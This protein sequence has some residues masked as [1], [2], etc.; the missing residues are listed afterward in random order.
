[1]FGGKERARSIKTG[2]LGIGFLGPGFPLGSRVSPIRKFPRPTIPTIPPAHLLF[3]VSNLSIPLSRHH[4][5]RSLA[6]FMSFPCAVLLVCDCAEMFCVAD[7]EL[8]IPS[9]CSC[10][11]FLFCKKSVT[12]DLTVTGITVA[13]YVLLPPL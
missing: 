7:R 2:Q 13:L 9:L 4:S 12:C 10:A 3:I 11:S 6:L 8:Y 5:P 1:M